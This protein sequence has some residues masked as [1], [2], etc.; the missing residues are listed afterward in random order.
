MSNV[1]L[2]RLNESDAELRPVDDAENLADLA[3]TGADAPDVVDAA[4]G[5]GRQFTSADEDGLAAVDVDTGSTLLTR[6]ASIQAIASWDIEAADAYGSPQTLYA[7]GKG[8]AS[9]EYVGAG[10]ELRVVN[11]ALRIGE[12]RWIWHDLSGV[13]KTQT[14][15]HFQV[16]ADGFLLLTATR[17]WVSSTRVVL[18]YYLGD[19]LLAEVESVD[20][21]I[22]GGTTGTTSIGTRYTGAAWEQFF[23]GVI[24]E[25]RVTDD[26]LTAEEV[27]ATWRRITIEQPRGYQLVREMHDPGF[28]ISMDP[29]SRAQ[30][31]TR[32]WGHA[33][34]FAAAQAEN[35]RE[36]ILPDR[37]YGRV[38]ERW[39][40]ITK[41]A[42]KPGDGVDTRRR[43]VVGRIRQ[44]LGVSIPGVGVA[45]EELVDTEAENLEIYAFD[46]TMVEDFATLNE[47]RWHYNP[48]AAFTIAS[49]ALR[50]QAAAV[51][52]IDM[53]FDW[54]RA[55]QSIGGNG[56]GAHLIAK[57]DPTTIADDAEVGFY[58]ENRITNHA[59]LFGMRRV[60]AGDVSLVTEHFLG[61][62]G[63]G[64]VVREAMGAAVA[65]R[66][67]QIKFQEPAE[68][69]LFT[70]KRA[71]SSS[72]P[73]TTVED[74]AAP[75]MTTFHWCGVYVRA[76]DGSTVTLDASVDDFTVRAPYGDRSFR[77]YVLRDPSLPGDADYLGANAVINGLRQAHTAAHVVQT[78]EALYDDDSTIYDDAPMGGQ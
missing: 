69:A 4:T 6:D 19:E 22:G 64:A 17:R 15:G 34:G 74:I 10:L 57:L 68:D 58:F 37:A 24:D 67:L 35:I 43:R 77:F 62:A 26:E 18:R 2:L 46:Q 1:L 38:L 61:G 41:Q 3:K 25:L 30:R 65:D 29:G 27:V 9:A 73:W 72:G 12:L 5:R 76:V 33:L 13:L 42:P 63:Q 56:R 32:L 7:R 21:E 47:T 39:E 20:G 28:P 51:P 50:V 59:F 44:R 11:A 49:G 55:K 14:G 16:P 53:L 45:L 36:N 40:A 48:S 75:G 66:W 31:E 8:T 23:D 78:L 71:T 60:S 52:A 70:V 54:Y